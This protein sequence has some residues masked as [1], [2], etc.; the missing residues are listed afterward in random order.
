MKREKYFEKLKLTKI[1]QILSWIPLVIGA[2]LLFVLPTFKASLGALENEWT[3]FDLFSD[4]YDSLAVILLIMGLSLIAAA[5]SFFTSLI[6]IFTFKVCAKKD[7]WDAKIKPERISKIKSQAKTNNAIIIVSIICAV[8]LIAGIVCAV[9]SFSQ[10]RVDME[11][12]DVIDLHP[13]SGAV[14]FIILSIISAIAACTVEIYKY[15]L[16]KNVE[17]DGDTVADAETLPQ[18]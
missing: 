17:P 15:F 10:F 3:A 11:I 12:P 13:G 4:E 1:L 5:L 14:A 8:L 2:V 6:Q 7:L 18:A 16:A 9:E